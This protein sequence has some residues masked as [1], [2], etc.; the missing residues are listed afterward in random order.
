[1]RDILVPKVYLGVKTMCKKF[2]EVPMVG[3][4]LTCVPIL[5]TPPRLFFG[6]GASNKHL[7]KSKNHLDQLNGLG[8]G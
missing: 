4:H 5:T 7:F 2:Q 6:N 3:C 8:G 1:M